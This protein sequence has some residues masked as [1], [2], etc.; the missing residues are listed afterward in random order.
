M[1]ISLVQESNGGGGVSNI[2]NILKES[3]SVIKMCIDERREGNESL[4]LSDGPNKMGHDKES[5]ESRVPSGDL[6]DKAK[7]STRNAVGKVDEEIVC[8]GN[9][10][11]DVSSNKNS[12]SSDVTSNKNST[13]TSVS[14]GRNTSSSKNSSRNSTDPVTGVGSSKNNSSRSLESGG[15]STS[16]MNALKETNIKLTTRTSQQSITGEE[17]SSCEHGSTPLQGGRSRRKQSRRTVKTEKDASVDEMENIENKNKNHL[18]NEAPKN[19]HVDLTNEAQNRTYPDKGAQSNQ[20][21]KKPEPDEGVQRSNRNNAGDLHVEV[22]R[23]KK[24]LTGRDVS[25]KT[26][27]KIVEDVTKT[28][29]ASKTSTKQETKVSPSGEESNKQEHT[30]QQLQHPESTTTKLPECTVLIDK[31]NDQSGVQAEKIDTA[32]KDTNAN[33][34]NILGENESLTTADTKKA[35][36][37]QEC[38]PGR[39]KRRKPGKDDLGGKENDGKPTNSMAAFDKEV[40]E[41]VSASVRPKRQVTQKN[42]AK[43]DNDEES[44]VEE[45]KVLSKR[46]V[47]KLSVNSKSE[48]NTEGKTKSK[49]EQNEVNTGQVKI[50]RN[51]Q[52]GAKNKH[53][54]AVED[55][56]AMEVSSEVTNTSEPG[57]NSSKQKRSCIRKSEEQTSLRKPAKDSEVSSEQTVHS[58]INVSLKNNSEGDDS[59]ENIVLD[60][61]LKETQDETQ[62]TS[63]EDKENVKKNDIEEKEETS[64]RESKVEDQ[65]KQQNKC[66][67]NNETS[68]KTVENKVVEEESIENKDKGESRKTK[69]KETTSECSD[70]SPPAK[71]SRRIELRK[72]K[73]ESEKQHEEGDEEAGE[74][75][76]RKRKGRCE[77]DGVRGKKKRHRGDDSDTDRK[78]KE[79]GPSKWGKRFL[80]AGLLSDT[81]KEDGVEASK[82]K[83]SKL[84]DLPGGLLPAPAYCNK[85]VR[86]RRIDFKLP[87]DLWWLHTHNLLPGRNAVP[88]WNYKKIRTNVYYDTKPNYSCYEAQACNCQLPKEPDK[89]GC[90]EDCLNRLVY[91][92]CIPSM[93]PCGTQCANQS[94]ARHEWAPGLIRFMTDG[95]GWG[96]KTRDEIKAGT[97]ILEYVGE[98]V[99]EKEFKN[100]MGTIYANDTHHYCLNLDKG[101]V[102]DGHRMGGDGRFVNHSCAPNC[103][104]QKWSVNGLF[105]MALFSLV[106]VPSGTE[107]TY[108]YNFSLFNPAEGQRCRCGSSNCRGVIGGKS[109]RV[110]VQTDCDRNKSV[111]TLGNNKSSPGGSS[112][113]SSS[114]KS[115]NRK[116]ELT[117]CLKSSSMMLSRRR[118][119]LN[120][121]VKF[122]NLAQRFSYLMNVRVNQLSVS[123]QQKGFIRKH[124]VFLV[125]NLVKLKVLRD[126]LLSKLSGAG[127]GSHP[128]GVNDLSVGS[129]GSLTP[130]ASSEAFMTTLNALST[131][132]S[133]RTRRLALAEDDPNL[134]KAVKLATLLRTLHQDVLS[135]KDDTSQTVL[136]SFFLTLPS[137]KKLSKYY[138][139]IPDPI[140][141]NTIDLNISSGVYK[142]LASYDCDM[143]RL[144][145]NA[146]KYYGRT[147]DEGIAATKL[148]KVYLMSKVVHSEELTR[149]LGEPLPE[150][151][152]PL[153]GE[154]E[155]VIQCICGLFKDEG[156]MIQ[157]ERCLVWQHCDCVKA[158][159]NAEHYLCEKCSP[160][161][162]DY[163]IQLDYVPEYAKPGETHYMSLMREDMLLREGDH[164]YVLRDIPNPATGHRHSFKT[165]GSEFKYEDCD[166]FKVERLWKN[167]AGERFAFGHHY[168]RPHETYHEPSR[169]FFDNE[170]MRIPL[171]EVVPLDLIMARCYVLDLATY[172]KGR[173]VDSSPE[174]IYISEFRLDK[175]ARL[176]AK[177]P[178]P[179]V[180]PVCMKSYAFE[181]FK[182]KLRPVRAYTPH[183]EQTKQVL[184]GGGTN[185]GVNKGGGGGKVTPVGGSR[186][187][188]GGGSKSGGTPRNIVTKLSSNKLNYNKR[189]GQKARLNGILLKL[190]AQE[191]EDPNKEVLDASYLL[192]PGKRQR[193]KPPLLNS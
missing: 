178:K 13:S 122:K 36:D 169:K 164:V 110:P 170:V 113:S 4:T 83:P 10:R 191:K 117:H 109:Q 73:K 180:S 156:L 27:N 97:F 154:E 91:T 151:F 29:I 175:G 7:P 167:E 128:G 161:P 34:S 108:D 155:D 24:S 101:L 150:N 192:D 160:K 129:T 23:E 138:E 136:S 153:G 78:K 130:S 38:T 71:K 149:V 46:N 190:L 1:A 89:R 112:T 20:V 21:Q 60:V 70:L 176:F 137:K 43:K 119:S 81:Y 88:S 77:K 157:C 140:D 159:P 116:K 66:K 6:V 125:R 16:S 58:N 106:D 19:K 123:A 85:W 142:N 148:R 79:V 166:I 93:C 31:M 146:A 32:E 104:M 25:S 193:K 17:K 57:S 139:T 127:S 131:K 26:R 102:I 86:Q 44:I 82:T 62:T 107:L 9:E 114:R 15:V 115:H 145:N 94:I 68:E 76:I 18:L 59:K 45:E 183:M 177:M 132:R 51:S 65:V 52:E 105:R 42:L 40:E 165:I 111:S 56:A 158:D 168:L 72:Q 14:N 124:H 171:Y 188:G 8:K 135:A 121:G 39:P 63:I 54:K 103:E 64:N 186:S 185:G 61:R 84:E 120:Q 100:R 67:T 143:L 69:A 184:G 35:T 28:T 22:Q 55:N 33:N 92:E 96:V 53:V 147:T 90:G 37:N 3:S 11:Y 144:F 163:E 5:I 48:E 172:C 98:V 141:L 74:G 95:K 49:S 80:S 162:V 173:P 87:H 30:H 181:M 174:H 99:S 189:D 179:K 12:T 2:A 118:F 152:L 126:K 75:K 47:K 133:C 41:L 50:T 182:E 134:A 187:G